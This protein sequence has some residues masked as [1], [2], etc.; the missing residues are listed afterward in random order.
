MEFLE[1]Y[2]MKGMMNEYIEIPNRKDYHELTEIWEA[3][4][5]ATHHFLTEAD[6]HFFKPLILNEYL[7]SVSLFCIKSP[8]G[9]ISGFMGL[10]EEKIEMLFVDSAAFGKGFGKALLRFAISEKGIRKVDVNEQ[11]EQAI[12]FYKYMGFEVIGRSELDGS[13][14]PFPILHLMLPADQ[15]AVR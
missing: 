3:S 6:I 11:N 1:C 15:V 2:A 8:V 14:K 12:A 4:V 9:N 5:R 10:S 7:Q 13:G